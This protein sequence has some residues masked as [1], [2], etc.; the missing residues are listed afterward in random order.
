MTPINNVCEELAGKKKRKTSH[1]EK[2]AKLKGLK[3]LRL[4][5]RK[6][7]RKRKQTVGS[8]RVHSLN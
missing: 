1:E 3:G 4:E 2:L 5:L 7:I 8:S 6:K